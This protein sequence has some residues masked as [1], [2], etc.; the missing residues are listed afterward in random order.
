MMFRNIDSIY[1]YIEFLCWTWRWP[2]RT[3]H[4]FENNKLLYFD[5]TC[6]NSDCPRSTTRMKFLQ[7]NITG[8]LKLLKLHLAV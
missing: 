1:I 4:V 2:F 6:R 3:K 8:T 7:K 5:W